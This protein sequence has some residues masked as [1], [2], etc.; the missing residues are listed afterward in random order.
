FGGDFEVSR[1]G[2]GVDPTWVR[3][4][5]TTPHRSA[6]AQVASLNGEHW[7]RHSKNRKSDASVMRVG[8]E[9][10]LGR[11]RLTGNHVTERREGWKPARSTLRETR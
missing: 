8:T 10:E 7:R 9:E 1:A 5:A 11:E 2:L 6:S 4:R 3:N